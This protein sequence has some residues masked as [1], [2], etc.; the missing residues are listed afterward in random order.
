M[1]F[2]TP[3]WRK[4]LI[5]SHRYLIKTIIH[6]VNH[7]FISTLCQPRHLWEPIIRCYIRTCKILIY[8]RNR[9][10]KRIIAG[11]T[12]KTGGHIER[13]HYGHRCTEINLINIIPKNGRILS[14]SN[15]FHSILIKHKHRVS[16][17]IN[18]KRY[19]FG[20]HLHGRVQE[21]QCKYITST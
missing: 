15:H 5:I 3:L 2:F 8:S 16:Y 18:K 14:F 21:L 10:A 1:T 19:T 17:R 11:R 4:P 12:G 9:H 6:G 7:I 20:K 13:I